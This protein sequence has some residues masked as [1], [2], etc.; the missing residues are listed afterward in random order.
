MLMTTFWTIGNV[1][2]L[3]HIS[4]AFTNENA[5]QMMSPMPIGLAILLTVHRVL[6]RPSANS[7]PP[8]I[9]E[10]GDYCA[11]NSEPIDFRCAKLGS[12]A[13]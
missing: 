8:C 13:R 12:L 9:A 10:S 6:R 5:R 11:R 3:Q 1:G 7:S 2:F 4:M